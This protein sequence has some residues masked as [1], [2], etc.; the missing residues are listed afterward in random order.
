MVS[1]TMS[2][3][4]ALPSCCGCRNGGCHPVDGCLDGDGFA[5]ADFTFLS[6]NVTVDATGDTLFPP[7]VIENYQGA[8]VA[9][10]GMTLEG[11]P[12][13]VTQSGVAGLTFHDEVETVN[14]LIPELQKKKVEAIVVLLHEG[15]FSSGGPEG[16]GC[17]DGLT[18]PLRSIVE[19]FDDAV[20][21]VIAGHV[22]DEFVCEVDGK[23]VTMADNNGRLYTD[24]D[25]TI[26]KRTNEL[27]VVAI[28]NVPTYQSL[29][30]PGAG[31]HRPDRQVQTRCQR[32]A[33][34]RGDRLNHGRHSRGVLAGGRGCRSET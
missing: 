10:I 17:A 8:K 19:G 14:A 24:I 11:T 22:N 27:T 9:F 31:S 25:V 18:D 32:P 15:G 12:S 2:S 4:R 23:W 26:D 3:T 28:D 5:G 20:D 16:D 7:Y 21:L 1:A 30:E 34:Q 33:G 13:I 29:V 6:A